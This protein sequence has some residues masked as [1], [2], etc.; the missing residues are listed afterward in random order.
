MNEKNK[1]KNLNKNDFLFLL[2]LITMNNWEI[3]K[4]DNNY[5]IDVNFPYQ[6]RN[7]HTLRIIREYSFN[8]GYV[9][10]ILSGKK[11]YKHRIVAN[12]FIDNPNNLPQVD[13]IDNNKQNNNIKNLR[14][15]S[16]S[17]NLKNRKKVFYEYDY[18]G[19]IPA[20]DENEIIKVK[21]YAKYTF[22]NLYYYDNEFYL[23]N[24]VRY[25]KLH[26]NE[27]K[28]GYY[29]VYAYDTTGKQQKIYLAKFKE[30]YN[31]Q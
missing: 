30:E 5:E 6:I 29:F 20:D 31:M 27:T 11:Y 10:C 25:R 23:F 2:K 21:D 19:I 4:D 7:R 3:L 22:S 24:G 16:A 18:C 9:V 26:L 13:H 14:W 8:N 12:Q 28:T 17:D 15:V 1:N